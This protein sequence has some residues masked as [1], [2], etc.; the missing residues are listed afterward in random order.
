MNRSAEV[1]LKR[2]IQKGWR[3]S[4]GEVVTGAGVV[5]ARGKL[6]RNRRRSYHRLRGAQLGCRLPGALFSNGLLDT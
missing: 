3:A 4:W 1:Q 6:R 2:G 5:R